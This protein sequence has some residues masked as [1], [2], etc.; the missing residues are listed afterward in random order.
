MDVL[1][2]CPDCG[3]AVQLPTLRT[4]IHAGRDH[5]GRITRLDVDTYGSGE[6]HCELRAENDDTT[7]ARAMLDGR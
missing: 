4:T 7:A 6:H 1:A 5:R 2:R 3:E